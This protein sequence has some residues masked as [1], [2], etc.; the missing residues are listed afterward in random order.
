MCGK[1][2]PGAKDQLA[3]L[4]AR[5]LPHPAG[6]RERSDGHPF[7]G[8]AILAPSTTARAGA[9]LSPAATPPAAPPPPPGLDACLADRRRIGL[10]LGLP[11]RL[12]RLARLDQVRPGHLGAMRPP[13]VLLTK[14]LGD[15]FTMGLAKHRGDRSTHSWTCHGHLRWAGDSA[16]PMPAIRQRTLCGNPLQ[17]AMPKP[18]PRDQYPGTAKLLVTTA[19]AGATAGLIDAAAAGAGAAATG[20]GASRKQFSTAKAHC[21]PRVS[22][23]PVGPV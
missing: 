2:R 22:R 21:S 8:S 7:T 17:T 12:P 20:M 11:G 5:P 23:P 1:R 10:P 18:Q 16:R 19:G 4:T 14:E 9:H 3:Q 13:G 15:N 6:F